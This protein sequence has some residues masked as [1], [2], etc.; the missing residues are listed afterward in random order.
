[1]SRYF[2]SKLIALIAGIILLL[3]A[4][5]HN[6]NSLYVISGNAYG[7]TWSV[8]S[9]QYIA[10]NH[11]E[12]IKDIINDIDYIASNYKSKSEISKINLNFKQF[13]F[14]SDDLFEIFGDEKV[15]G[16]SLGSD[17]TSNKK[18][19]LAILAKN[20][21]K[22]RWE[23]LVGE[24]DGKNLDNIRKFLIESG[25]K[26]KV[27]KIAFDYFS[28]AY[29]SLSKFG[30]HNNSELYSFFKFIQERHY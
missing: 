6:A 7:T 16:K 28:N 4:Y 2:F 23:K 1:M 19:P 22:I 8:S 10:D 3:I 20:E 24:Y 30:I 26:N 17:I 13:Q 18:T 29:D 15:M 11:K 9:P 21:D 14:V 5:N 25:V 12:A 27:D